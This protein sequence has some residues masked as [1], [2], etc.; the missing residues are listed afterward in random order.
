L[1]WPLLGVLGC[2]G[3]VVEQ[4][5]SLDHAP[6]E[7]H[8]F[9]LAHDHHGREATTLAPDGQGE[10]VGLSFRFGIKRSSGAT[11]GATDRMLCTVQPRSMRFR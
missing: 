1:V 4:R 8:S 11:N 6:L 2:L 7:A 5:H 9:G 3:I 10:G